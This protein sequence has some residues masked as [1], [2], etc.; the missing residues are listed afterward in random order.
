MEK[1][2][3]GKKIWKRNIEVRKY[4]KGITE[5]KIR[6]RHKEMKRNKEREH[7]KKEQKKRKPQKK[8]K[9]KKKKKNLAAGAANQ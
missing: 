8:N 1:E 4:G 7:Q 5:N 9:K 3:K 6:K 2:H